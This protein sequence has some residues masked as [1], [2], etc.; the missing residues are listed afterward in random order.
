MTRLPPREP[1][2]P[3]YLLR[4]LRDEVHLMTLPW[5]NSCTSTGRSSHRPAQVAIIPYLSRMSP[6]RRVGKVP[7][8]QFLEVDKG[9]RTFV[10]TF[11]SIGISFDDAVMLE[12]LRMGFSDASTS[13]T[14]AAQHMF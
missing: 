7:H 9:V 3:Y 8:D 1:H 5:S 13:I 14:E 11:A 10:L 12:T 4:L 2:R 6:A